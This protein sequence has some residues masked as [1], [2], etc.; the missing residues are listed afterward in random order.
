MEFYVEL[1]VTLFFLTIAS[2]IYTDRIYVHPFI[3]E[4]VRLLSGPRAVLM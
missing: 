4:I 3:V 1:I 2:F